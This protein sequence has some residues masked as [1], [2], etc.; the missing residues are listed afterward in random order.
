MKINALPSSVFLKLKLAALSME[1]D[2]YWVK[3]RQDSTSAEEGS[4]GV[5]ALSWFPGFRRIGPSGVPSHKTWRLLYSSTRLQ[6]ICRT[7]YVKEILITSESRGGRK[8][9]IFEYHHRILII[10]TSTF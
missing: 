3:R 4:L 6:I 8:V 9:G 2:S 7:F 5:L 1:P 10:S